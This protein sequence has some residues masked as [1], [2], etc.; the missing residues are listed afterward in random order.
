MSDF[1]GFRTSR[2]GA[3]P[4]SSCGQPFTPPQI[5]F[6]GILIYQGKAH[7]HL[8]GAPLVL[9]Y[10]TNSLDLSDHFAEPWLYFPRFV[11]HESP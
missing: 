4:S 3:S 6:P 2:S 10:S 1:P 11:R 5:S 7:P 9:T 8:R